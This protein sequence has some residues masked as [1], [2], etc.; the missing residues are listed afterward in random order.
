MDKG[1]VK[2]RIQQRR[3]ALPRLYTVLQE[4]SKAASGE[5]VNLCRGKMQRFSVECTHRFRLQAANRILLRPQQGCERLPF[6]LLRK[7]L[8]KLTQVRG[9]I[10]SVLA[11]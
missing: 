11:T 9:K 10:R 2:L 7:L 8:A 3:L 6:Y 4:V 5:A 1:A